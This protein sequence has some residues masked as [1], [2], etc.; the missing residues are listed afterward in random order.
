M[1]IKEHVEDAG[2]YTLPQA[3]AMIG[4]HPDTLRR[5]I[6]A[7]LT[8][9]PRTMDFGSLSVWVFSPEDVA[10]LQ[11]LAGS[12]RIGRPPVGLKPA[13]RDPK[14]LRLVSLDNYTGRP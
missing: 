10:S 2:L 5:W 8:A 11:E 7:G 13:A 6:R 4:R 3:A 14:T 9:T 1:S 12:I